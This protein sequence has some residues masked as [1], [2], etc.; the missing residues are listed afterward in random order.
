MFCFFLQMQA[1]FHFICVHAH[2]YIH[3]SLL[4]TFYIVFSFCLFEDNE[5]HFFLTVRASGKQDKMVVECMS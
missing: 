5:K 3:A 1:I 2:I 4:S